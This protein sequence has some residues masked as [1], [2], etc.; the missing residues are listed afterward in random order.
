MNYEELVNSQE[1]T[2]ARRESMPF[3]FF[4][5]KQIDRKYRYV[6]ELRPDLTDSL[7][8]SEGLHQDQHEVKSI[9]DAHQLHYELHE[10]SGGIYEMELQPGSYQT[11]A[12]L[13]ASQPAV[14]AQKGF[15][16]NTLNAVMNLVELLHERGIY[17]LCFS[18]QTVLMR[19]GENTPLLLCHGSSFLSM[20]EQRVL[21][22]G[23]ENDVAPEVLDEAKADERS[24]VYAL[25]RFIEHLL[26]SSALGYEY[27]GVV[28]KA[29]A[30]NPDDR[31][32]TVH[33]M[34]TAIS[35]KRNT[36][37]T[38][39]LAVAAGAVVAVLVGIFFSL[40]R[41]PSTVEFI[42]DN[43]Q[44]VKPDPFAEQFNDEYVDDQDPYIDPE[45]AL[46]LDSIE[47][48]TDEEVKILSDS[49]KVNEQL[50]AIFRRRFEQRARPSLEAIYGNDDSGTSE[51]DYIA[52]SQK[53]MKELYDYAGELSQ[54]TGIGIDDANSQASQIIANL[55][56]EMQEKAKRSGS[57]T[58][59][60]EEQ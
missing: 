3:G 45:I 6:V 23:Y 20:K 27:K 21:Y 1:S 38:L 29:T 9:S 7:L 19:K 50:N 52:K 13:L 46:Y 16:S 49:I 12:Q 32:A 60:Q 15:V 33:E 43:G 11:L 10:D 56:A 5:R 58:K 25:G 42:D 30:E 51:S 18:P 55:Q 35:S 31:Y 14:V 41:E 48:M 57:L 34:R 59:P 36:R 53:V 54:Q 4:Y 17:H 22:K 26:E 44:K 28:K 2:V 37:R 39:W 8:F 40:V 24:D 47:P